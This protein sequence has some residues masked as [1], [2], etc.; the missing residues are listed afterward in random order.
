MNTF[1]KGA[2]FT[3]PFFLGFYTDFT[4]F[5]HCFAVFLPKFL[6]LFTLG[7]FIWAD[8]KNFP[9]C[10]LFMKTRT[11]SINMKEKEQRHAQ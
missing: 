10:P 2:V 11:Y 7:D 8:Q 5:L 6:L 4:F 9:V 1:M 3:A